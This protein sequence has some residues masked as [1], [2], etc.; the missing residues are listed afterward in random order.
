MHMLQAAKYMSLQGV[1]VTRRGILFGGLS[2]IFCLE[3]FVRNGFCPSSLLSECIHYNRRLNITFNVRF[4]MYN[5]FSKCDVTC[6]WPLSS[7]T[8]CDTFL[9]LLPLERDV[10]HGEPLCKPILTSIC[11]MFKTAACSKMKR[12]WY[13][14]LKGISQIQ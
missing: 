8:I 4:H 7:V 1:C 10:L 14:L 5:F 12:N 2:G 13:N 3:G 6:S 9:D 11:V